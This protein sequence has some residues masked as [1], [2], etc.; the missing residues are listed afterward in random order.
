MLSRQKKSE[1]N[2][3]KVMWKPQIESQLSSLMDISILGDPHVYVVYMDH[4]IPEIEKK[5]INI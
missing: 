3:A 4:P 2:K 1:K 5:E